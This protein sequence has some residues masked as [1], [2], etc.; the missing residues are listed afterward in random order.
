MTE[1]ERNAWRKW[2]KV[3]FEQARSGQSVAAFCRE[4]G[5]CAP[6]FFTWRKRL[7]QAEAAEFVE[8][9]LAAA[10][11]EAKL[12]FEDVQKGSY[13]RMDQIQRLLKSGQLGISLRGE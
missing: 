1:R 13:V 11:P 10:A 5:V 9:K 8:L 12:T 6:Q 7:R 4:R 3:V 2:R